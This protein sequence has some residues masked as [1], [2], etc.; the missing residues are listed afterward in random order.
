[1]KVFFRALLPFIFRQGGQTPDF[2]HELMASGMENK[3]KIQL[4]DL[5]KNQVGNLYGEIFGIEQNIIV[6]CT[7]HARHERP[8][9]QQ[10]FHSRQS[11]QYCSRS[12]FSAGEGPFGRK[13]VLGFYHRGCF[14]NEKFRGEGKTRWLTN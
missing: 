7:S 8:S 10:G 12:F 13:P 9:S 2:Y 11:S 3:F 4:H 5:G 14:L 6:R 1:M